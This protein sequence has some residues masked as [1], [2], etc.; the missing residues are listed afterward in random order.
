ME[1]SSQGPTHHHPPDRLHPPSPVDEQELYLQPT[2]SPRSHASPWVLRTPQDHPAQRTPAG[3]NYPHNDDLQ[4]HDPNLET[5]GGTEEE[6][7]QKAKR[8]II[9]GCSKPA[10]IIALFFVIVIVAAAIGGGVGGTVFANRRCVSLF[11]LLSAVAF[12]LTWTYASGV[13]RDPDRQWIN[14]GSG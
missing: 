3:E 9:C 4:Q 10:F 8:Q 14:M 11:V 12:L 7:Q 1:G 2:P 5:A 13:R 6:Q